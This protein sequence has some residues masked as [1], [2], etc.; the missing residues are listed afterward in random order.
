M[1]TNQE[2][3][4]LE[5]QK[6]LADYKGEDRIV[7]AEELLKEIKSDVAPI[8]YKTGLD[9]LDNLLG[10]FRR[11][12]LVVISAATGQG[13]TTFCQTLT[14][15]F[16]KDGHKVLWFSYEV[17]LEEFMEKMPEGGRAYHLPRQLKQNSILWL[18]ERIIEGIAKYNTRIIFFDHLHYLLE[19]QKMA[20]AKSLSLLI[21]MMLREIK[22]IAIEQNILF[23]LVSHVRNISL[24]EFPQLEHLRD[25]SFVGQESDI[26]LMMWRIRDSQDKS[27]W[28]YYSRI[29]VRKN[30]RLGKLGEVGLLF[31]GV[32]FIEGEPPKIETKVDNWPRHYE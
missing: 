6:K 27:L 17:G 30:R 11:G 12:Q 20:E 31:D 1:N 13:K 21:G 22:K 26:V 14:E 23:I 24:T 8:A 32:H 18:R 15:K 9:S 10:E 16:L 7:L 3:K 5:E 2:L 4:N 29:A 19:M 25:S 28:T